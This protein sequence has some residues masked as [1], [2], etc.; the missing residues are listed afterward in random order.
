MLGASPPIR[1]DVLVAPASCR[2]SC[3]SLRRRKSLPCCGLACRDAVGEASLADQTA[4]PRH[5]SALLRAGRTP[6]GA[7]SSVSWRPIPAGDFPGAPPSVCEGGL[8]GVTANSPWTTFPYTN[9]D[10]TPAPHA[11]RKILSI[12]GLRTA[13]PLARF[14]R[15]IP[16][17]APRFTRRRQGRPAFPSE[18]RQD[19]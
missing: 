3:L 17:V 7:R 5:P 1:R 16:R 15:Q 2:R 13:H 14:E 8:S 10:L 11:R 12:L 4:V 6:H 18:G 19:P 9:N